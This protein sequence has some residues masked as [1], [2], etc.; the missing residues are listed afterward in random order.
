M[1]DRLLGLLIVL[2]SFE[3]KVGV[4]SNHREISLLRFRQDARRRPPDD[5]ERLGRNLRVAA[6][7]LEQRQPIRGLLVGVGQQ[8][9]VPFVLEARATEAR[10]RAGPD[11]GLVDDGQANQV[12][13]AAAGDV[14][15]RLLVAESLL[16]EP[17]RQTR[18]SLI[19][20]DY[21]TKAGPRSERVRGPACDLLLVRLG[22]Y[23]SDGIAFFAAA[24]SATGTSAG[25]TCLMYSG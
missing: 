12:R 4:A 9:L 8:G 6:A 24:I 25:S 23:A 21:K 16:G 2:V 10:R 14:E 22:G 17:S 11:V 20:R 1:Q 7:A 19:M 15:S 5:L 3:S 18:I 13:A